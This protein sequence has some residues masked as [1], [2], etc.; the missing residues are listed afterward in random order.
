MTDRDRQTEIEAGAEAERHRHRHRHI[1][2]DIGR[3]RGRGR[4]RQTDRQ[5]DYRRLHLEVIS[6]SF[7]GY[8][9]KCYDCFST[10]SWDKCK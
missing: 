3:G 6:F 2:I 1:D 8:A 7:S 5:T 9:L 10:D 4:G